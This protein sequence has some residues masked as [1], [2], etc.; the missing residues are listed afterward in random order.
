[1]VYSSCAVAK[2]VL[3]VVGMWTWSKCGKKHTGKWKCW[4]SRL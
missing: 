4:V 2:R 1:M 3:E